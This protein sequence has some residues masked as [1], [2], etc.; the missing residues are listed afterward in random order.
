MSVDIYVL[1]PPQSPR[2]N[3]CCENGFSTTPPQW[4]HLILSG[5]DH[6]KCFFAV[7]ARF[8]GVAKGVLGEHREC[9]QRY[10]CNW[11]Q[12]ETI[13]ER[14]ITCVCVWCVKRKRKVLILVYWNYCTMVDRRRDVNEVSL[15]LQ[16]REPNTT[17]FLSRCLLKK[18]YKMHQRNSFNSL[19]A[20][21]T[22]AKERLLG[23]HA[24][25]QNTLRP[26][27]SF[28]LRQCNDLSIA[29]RRN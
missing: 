14:S 28:L 10:L 26:K 4:F 29:D 18:I 8:C 11:P 9:S 20:H 7:I 24:Y 19:V 5:H 2:D 13:H 17:A 3:T 23:P 21:L 27:S 6:L 1:W 15:P 22:L 12:N 25:P 16:T